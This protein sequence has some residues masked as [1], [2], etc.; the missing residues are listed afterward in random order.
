M[1]YG[2]ASQS[3]YRTRGGEA[4]PSPHIG[5]RR[6]DLNHLREGRCSESGG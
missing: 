4:H 3:Y 1:D 6:G 2:D 5:H